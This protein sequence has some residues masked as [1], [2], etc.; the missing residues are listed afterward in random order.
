MGDRADLS[1]PWVR[2]LVDFGLGGQAPWAIFGNVEARVFPLL[3]D[4]QRL[5]H[6]LDCYYNKTLRDTGGRL[7][8]IAPVVF[9]TVLF[10]PTIYGRDR[11]EAA[12]ADQQEYYFLV[13]VECHWPAAAHGET[14]SVGVVTPYIYVSS[15][16]SVPMGRELYG[17]QKS[18]YRV[19]PVPPRGARAEKQEP[20]LRVERPMPGRGGAALSY[21]PVLEVAYRLRDNPVRVGGSGLRSL[22]LLGELPH[23][24]TLLASVAGEEL[25][26]ARKPRSTAGQLRDLSGLLLDMVLPGRHLD[27][28]AMVQIPHPTIRSQPGQPPS[29]AA[30]YQSFMRTRLE[31]TNLHEASFLGEHAP[32]PLDPSAG[33]SLHISGGGIDQ[34]ATRLGLRAWD[35]RPGAQ[36]VI[37]GEYRPF[38]PPVYG[39]FDMEV[40]GVTTLARRTAAGLWRDGEGRPVG[41]APPSNSAAAYNAWLGPSVAEGFNSYGRTPQAVTYKVFGMRADLGT[42][43]QL[44]RDIAPTPPGVSLR[45]VRVGDDGLAVMTA[46][47]VERDARDQAPLTWFSGT[48]IEFYVLAELCCEGRSRLM[49]LETHGF[50]DNP[51]A[52]LVGRELLAANRWLG[53]I[54]ESTDWWRPDGAP[55]RLI[56]L[57]TALVETVNTGERIRKR[58]LLEVH[59]TG[60]RAPDSQGPGEY[61]QLLGSLL[62]DA[63]IE[64]MRVSAVPTIDA[65]RVSTAMV[66]CNVERVHFG[67]LRSKLDMRSPSSD[68]L[69]IMHYESMPIVRDLGLRGPRGRAGTSV[70]VSCDFEVTGSFDRVL[71][72]LDTLYEWTPEGWSLDRLRTYME[73]Q[74]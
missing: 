49:L 74:P 25:L 71:R 46:T 22:G 66:R 60:P 28:F 65:G 34:T 62:G 58:T 7:E 69:E 18:I 36:D 30:A 13:P 19:K 37:D 1:P 40:A 43:E 21:Q 44:C 2:S 35:Q 16:I 51:H 23:A 41:H 26:D 12:V 14:R 17:W 47:L 48:Y 15:P 73:G 63:E 20:Y 33:F 50:T 61:Q 42:L 10:Y 11:A 38:C 52:M 64:I 24:A 70:E 32:S 39:S 6:F 55:G 8:L 57:R 45:P 53:E 27:V 4:R 9:M 54:E 3:A 56:R 5:Q 72:H 29:F 59:R 31:V 68:T 67:G